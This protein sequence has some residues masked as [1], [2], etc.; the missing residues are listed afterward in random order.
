[1]LMT[2][3]VDNSYIHDLAAAARVS[4]EE[5]VVDWI[6][7]GEE[8]G[9]LGRVQRGDASGGEEGGC[10][11]EA[12]VDG[13]PGGRE[14]GGIG[15]QLVDCCA[16]LVLVIWDGGG[17]GTAYVS[18][19]CDDDEISLDDFTIRESNS[20]GFEIHILHSTPQPQRRRPSLPLPL[21]RPQ[22]SQSSM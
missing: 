17:R 13:A 10:R 22:L 6:Q 12:G 8:A 7:H 4:H 19:V 5:D 16:L 3:V 9:I 15:G 1:M 18:A 11:D 2:C 20:P 14:W 21:F